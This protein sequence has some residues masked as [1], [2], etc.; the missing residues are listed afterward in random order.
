MEVA[1]SCDRPW[2]ALYEP[3]MGCALAM[4]IG[5]S[6]RSRQDMDGEEEDELDTRIPLEL[7]LHV[8]SF[9]KN[10]FVAACRLACTCSSLRGLGRHPQIWE[11]WCRDAFPEARGWLPLEG[12]LRKYC[13]SWRTMFMLRPRLRLD[14]IYFISNTKLVRGLPEGRGM[15]EKD[16]DFYSPGGKWAIYYRIFKFYP[17]GMM[18]AYLCS[19]QNPVEVRKLA[20]GVSPARPASLQQKLRGACWGTYSLHE[21]EDGRVSLQAVV[22][23]RSEDYPR[24]KPATIGYKLEL[25]APHAGAT[26]CECVLVDH[27][28]VYDARTNDVKAFDIPN[29]TCVFMPSHAPAAKAKDIWKG[30]TPMAETDG[31]FGSAPLPVLSG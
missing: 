21:M 17:N 19:V 3:Q 5:E 26:N 6:A 28:C 23:L 14:G 30:C 31:I 22:P 7:W 2:L 10:D 16:E 1:A 27:R 9:L 24:M 11:R 25:R 8:C 18:F 12:Q 4:R 20:A 13:W 15:K 29:A